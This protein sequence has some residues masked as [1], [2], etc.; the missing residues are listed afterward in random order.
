MR[1]RLGEQQDSVWAS[2]KPG[3]TSGS[4]LGKLLTLLGLGLLIYGTGITLTARAD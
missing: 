2:R 1:D 3:L 4:I